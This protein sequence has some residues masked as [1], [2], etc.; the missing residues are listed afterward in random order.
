MHPQ[1]RLHSR[2]LTSRQERPVYAW[3]L[4]MALASLY[5][6]PLLHNNAPEAPTAL[7]RVQ[8]SG[9][10][11]VVMRASPAT[12]YPTPGGITGF[13]YLMAQQFAESLNVRLEVITVTSMDELRMVLANGSADFA[14]GVAF[15]ETGLPD[16]RMT[17]SYM[18]GEPLVIYRSPGARP[19]SFADLVGK[20]VLIAANDQHSDLL[21]SLKHALPA[22]AWSETTALDAEQLLS[23]VNNEDVDYT[24]VNANE[25]ILLRSYYTH[26][27][28]AFSLGQPQP[29]AW[30]FSDRN[31]TSLYETAQNFIASAKA[32][33][34]IAR[35]SERTY[36]SAL[37]M[38]QHGSRV[39]VQRVNQRLPQFQSMIEAVADEFDIDWRL[40]AA[41]SYQESHWD[42]AAESPTGV[43]GMMMLTKATAKE[44]GVHNRLDTNQSLRGGAQYLRNIYHRLPQSIAEPDRT[45]FALAA[46]N[47]GLG[48]LEDA[49]RITDSQGADPDTWVDV[50]QRLPLLK[51]ALWHGKSRHGYARGDEPVH[52]VQRIRH[53][54]DLL[55][56]NFPPQDQEEE[57]L[58]G[59]NQL[60][61]STPT[62]NATAKTNTHTL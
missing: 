5:L 43:R 28:S 14:A 10:L 56:W 37:A 61:Y 52:F 29:I 47:V 54:Y 6:L 39:F 27:K 8:Q 40:L 48:H 55:S 49:R 31:E 13:E 36:G 58:I 57:F 18:S 7:Q 60:A 15:G 26:L 2:Q 20:Q 11:R 59:L 12:Y 35:M 44:V 46:Y 53:Y 33:G 25:F 19:K 42:P 32:N 4:A 38:Q 16:L 24:V 1:T 30:A 23:A 22:L 50:K 34:S 17:D 62:Q 21:K 3:L 41:I 45:W 9:V 51:D